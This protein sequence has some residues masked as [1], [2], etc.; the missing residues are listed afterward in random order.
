MAT[1]KTFEDIEVWKMAFE[2]AVEIYKI[3][4][5]DNFLRDMRFQGQIRASAG[6]I[7]DNIAEGYERDGVKEFVQFLYYSKGSC[8]ESRSQLYRA[9]AVKYI[10]ESSYRSA[11]SKSQAI[12]KSLSGFINYLRNAEIKGNKYK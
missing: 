10:D 3:T 2:Y 6:S 8:G 7:M 9:F 1:F 12:S 4:D 11:L 5:N